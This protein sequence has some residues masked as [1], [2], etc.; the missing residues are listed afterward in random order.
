MNRKSLT[1]QPHMA[2]H[3]IR[4]TDLEMFSTFVEKPLQIRPIM[5]NKANFSPFFAQKRRFYRKTNPIQTQYKPKQTQFWHKNKD[6][7]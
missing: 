7:L 3:E 1:Y 2:L 5:Q 6:R 4:D